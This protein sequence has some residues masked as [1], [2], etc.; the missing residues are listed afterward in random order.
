MSEEA[1][2]VRVALRAAR[3]FEPSD[4]SVVRHGVVV[5]QDGRIE[6]V[7]DVPPANVPVLD[8]GDTTLL[9]G[10]IDTHTHML[11][12]PEDQVW[13]PAITFKTQ[14]YRMAEGVAAARTA[15]NIGFT[16]ARDTDNEGVWHG[17][18]A[19]RDAIDRGV[20]PGPRLKVASDAISITGADMRLVPE[21]NPELNLPDMSAM[22]DSPAAMI[23]EIRRQVK[24]GADWI[25]IYATSTR[26]DVDRATFEPLHQF[27]EDEMRLMVQEARRYRRDVAAHA[28]GGAGAAAAI[29][30]GARTIEHGVLLDEPILKLFLDHD[31]FW[32]PTA[33]TYYK[34][35]H[36]DFDQEF[37]RR[38][39][40]AFKTGLEL[41]VKIAFGTDVGSYPHGEQVDEL[42]IMVEY[43]MSPLQALQAATTVAA[44][45]MRMD[46]EVGTLRE[47]AFADLIAVEGDPIADIE[48]MKR[49][50]FVMKG[51]KVHR[52]ETRATDRHACLYWRPSRADR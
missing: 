18:T 28:Y 30:G 35:Q 38:H 13:P 29:R 51:G 7:T 48:C 27:S 1:G 24:I 12:R 14:V 39:K 11:L 32:V 15:L 50:Q 22:A 43:G 26:R 47:G 5:V 52:D 21:V 3:V 44:E 4:A 20:I 33:G 46:R 6:A 25:K 2:S 9:P 19:L 34:R 8:L 40:S 36:T 42:I 37:V 41:G 45:L 49:V 16:T 17:D 23:A 31:C 10:L